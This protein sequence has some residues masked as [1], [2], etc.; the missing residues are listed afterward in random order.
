MGKKSRSHEQAGNTPEKDNKPQSVGKNN[1]TEVFQLL[2]EQM[3]LDYFLQQVHV[4]R[5]IRLAESVMRN[6]SLR[7][8]VTIPRFKYILRSGLAV[9]SPAESRIVFDENYTASHAGITYLH[10][11][12]RGSW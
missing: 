10:K 11:L 3:Q 4:A 12:Q 8:K 2:P 6:I 7:K 9:C 1:N 5:E